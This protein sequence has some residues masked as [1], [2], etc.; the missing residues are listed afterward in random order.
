[1]PTTDLYDFKG[2]I[3]FSYDDVASNEV[4]EDAKND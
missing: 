4:A 2:S 3:E 1:M